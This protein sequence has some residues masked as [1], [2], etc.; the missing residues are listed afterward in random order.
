LNQLLKPHE[1]ALLLGVPVSFVYDRTRQNSP[2][3]IPH[4]KL[5]KYV[6]FDLAQVQE[7][8]AERTR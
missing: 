1:L 3:P 7:W 5:G 8:L 4:F 2:D 6:R